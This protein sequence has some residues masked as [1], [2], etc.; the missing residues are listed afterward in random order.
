VFGV[1]VIVGVI[2]GVGCPFDVKAGINDAIKAAS[3]AAIPPVIVHQDARH[4]VG[5]SDSRERECD[6]M[7]PLEGVLRD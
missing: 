3:A 6:V 1:V 5:R 4:A 2:C 7:L